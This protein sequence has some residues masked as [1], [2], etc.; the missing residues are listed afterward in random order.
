[1]TRRKRKNVFKYVIFLVLIGLVA[2]GGFLIWQNIPKE[3]PKDDTETINTTTQT[4]KNDEIKTEENKVENNKDKVEVYKNKVEQFD[5]GNPN[6]NTTI[7]GA[8]TYAGVVDDSLMI[9]ANID[10]YLTGGE[11]KLQIIKDG[12]VIYNETAE[13][14]DSAATATCKGFNVAAS[15]L[16]SGK[17]SIN[18]LVTSGEKTGTIKGEA[19]L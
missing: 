17:V 11:C 14:A 1:M 8:I 4:I 19:T 10:Q 6:E 2:L 5:G 13:I 9:R 12:S 16:G 18:I 3:E 15:G 7:S